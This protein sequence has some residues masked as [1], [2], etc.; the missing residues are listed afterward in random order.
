MRLAA[1]LCAVVASLPSDGSPPSEDAAAEAEAIGAAFAASHAFLQPPPIEPTRR[2]SELGAVS[3]TAPPETRVGRF[4]LRC[5]PREEA[6]GIGRRTSARMREKRERKTKMMFMILLHAMTESSTR[7]DPVF[8]NAS[9]G[10]RG[11]VHRRGE[12]LAGVARRVGVAVA[13]DA[14]RRRGLVS[15]SRPSAPALAHQPDDRVS[16]RN[17]ARR[18]RKTRRANTRLSYADS[19]SVTVIVEPLRRASPVSVRQA[20]A[21][22]RLSRNPRDRHLALKVEARNDRASFR[23]GFADR[24]PPRP[25]PRTV[26]TADAASEPDAHR[27]VVRADVRH[28]LLG[29]AEAASSRSSRRTSAASRSTM[30]KIARRP[31]VDRDRRRAR[32]R[33]DPAASARRRARR[34]ER[35]D[36]CPRVPNDFHPSRPALKLANRGRRGFAQRSSPEAHRVDNVASRARAN[37]GP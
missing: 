14:T 32:S 24:T 2:R 13:V 18:P 26:R 31:V 37:A 23:G 30:C 36:G 29:V 17:G 7:V 6:A 4:G 10:W 8:S 35:R 20:S 25:R 34:A 19:T 9:S 21:G 22:R 1:N 33:R 3:A 12:I 15:A 27:R 11:A 5:R 16:S 28:V